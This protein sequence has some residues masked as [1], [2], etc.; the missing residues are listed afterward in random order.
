MT[1]KEAMRKKHG[2]IL[3]AR[4]LH[5]FFFYANKFREDLSD[6]DKARFDGIFGRQD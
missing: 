2:R 6:D 5:I 4:I 1:F 3:S